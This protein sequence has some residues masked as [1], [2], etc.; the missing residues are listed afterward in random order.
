VTSC[1]PCH[2]SAV[3]SRV[4]DLRRS[5]P[6]DALPH[7]R[8]APPPGLA[9]KGL[10][11]LSVACAGRS[12]PPPGETGWLWPSN[13]ALGLMPEAAAASPRSP[14][15]ARNALALEPYPLSLRYHYGAGNLAVVL[16]FPFSSF[17]MA[18]IGNEYATCREG[19]SHSQILRKTANQ[20][21]ICR[22]RVE[23][24]NRPGL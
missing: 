21:R 23:R 16:A 4:T 2:C 19:D 7:G 14:L 5:S 8:R 13:A 1:K 6:N 22:S 17:Y 18:P 15:K 12:P 24:G 3:R 10:S 11:L 9:S 20:S